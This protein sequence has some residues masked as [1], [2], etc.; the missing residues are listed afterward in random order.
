MPCF[1]LAV[2]LRFPKMDAV[3][4]T[5]VVKQSASTM[6]GVFASMLIPAA[7]AL[8]YWKLG[9]FLAAESFLLCCSGLFLVLA[10]VLWHWVL[11]KG[12]GILKE[13]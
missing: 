3:N 1:G 12:P 11:K 9:T 7:A 4:D 10:A 5:L 6:I 2:N 8:V 13:L